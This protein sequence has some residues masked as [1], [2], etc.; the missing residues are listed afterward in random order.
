MQIIYFATQPG[1]SRAQDS[2]PGPL[3]AEPITLTDEESLPH[4]PMST[5]DLKLK[6][7]IFFFF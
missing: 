7:K 5:F 3:T 1:K 2:N 4:A 6:K